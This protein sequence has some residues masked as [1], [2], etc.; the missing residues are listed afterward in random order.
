MAVKKATSAV[1]RGV[2]P[3]KAAPADVVPTQTPSGTATKRA[4]KTQ[5]KTRAT[6]ETAPKAT[7]KTGGTKVAPA[8][9]PQK[10]GATKV[11]AHK[12][13]AKASATTAEASAAKESP[14]RGAS[15]PA[16]PSVQ[17]QHLRVLENER[18]WTVKE[19]AAVRSEL[20]ADLARLQQEIS[21]AA[22]ALTGLMHDVGDGAGDD[23]ADAG[24][25]TFER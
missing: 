21:V 19:L 23:P 20:E 3:A 6:S 1:T 2:P 14:G 9:T 22:V 5:A 12:T 4:P 18:A 25:A 15:I 10:A 16:S 13:T 11:T 24:T 17:P 7:A 8:K